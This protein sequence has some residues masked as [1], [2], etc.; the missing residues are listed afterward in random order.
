MGAG[1]QLTAEVVVKERAGAQRQ[2]VERRGN[3]QHPRRTLRHV[4]RVFFVPFIRHEAA[5]LGKAVC[6][7]WRSSSRAHLLIIRAVCT[8][9]QSRNQG[10]PP[11]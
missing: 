4:V 9:Q 10:L 3:G 5:T 2:R 8:E 1:A 11:G 6:P 7:A